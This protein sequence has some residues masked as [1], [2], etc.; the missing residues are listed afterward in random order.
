MLED[1]LKRLEN[2][3]TPETYSKANFKERIGVTS[4]GSEQ[5]SPN[6]DI[7]LEDSKRLIDS[8]LNK[9]G[10]KEQD[11]KSFSEG[12]LKAYNKILES[13][14]KFEHPPDE[15]GNTGNPSR[16]GRMFSKDRVNEDSVAR[17]LSYSPNKEDIGVLR[18]KIHNINLKNMNYRHEIE[19]LKANINNLTKELDEQRQ[20]I[21]K[22][23]RQKESDNKY[24][25]KLEGML[26]NSKSSSLLS[27]KTPTNPNG[28]INDLSRI[29]STHTGFK[30]KRNTSFNDLFSVEFSKNNIL[31]EEKGNG[32]NI[33]NVNDKEELRML[34]LNLLTENK[35]LKD[36]Q[37]EVFEISKSYDNINEGMMEAIKGIQGLVKDEQMVG[38]DPKFE[39]ISRFI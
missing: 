4:R 1:Y 18:E 19:T 10:V 8:Y 37:K 3:I 29:T 9:M 36:F 20:L 34:V 17:V 22:Y 24:L 35:K 31:I 23:E 12:R 6:K 16:T 2:L 32:G 14:G 5:F 13:E 28:A 33:L 25:L 38:D 39:L 30:N 26:Q 27:F 15:V 7:V 21:T 11:Q